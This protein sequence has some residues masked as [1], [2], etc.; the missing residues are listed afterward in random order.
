MSHRSRYV[1]A[2]V[3]VTCI[4]CGVFLATHNIPGGGGFGPTQIL[5]LV[6]SLGIGN[7]VAAR[8]LGRWLGRV[9]LGK[10]M[11][12]IPID[13]ALV[14]LCA[15]APVHLSEFWVGVVDLSWTEMRRGLESAADGYLASAR[16]LSKLESLVIFVGLSAASIAILWL[17]ARGE[18]RATASEPRIQS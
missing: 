4:W 10:A 15:L 7:Y 1:I 2:V 11:L 3:A 12:A 17:G 8:V 5:T 9:S 6:A 16:Q 13:L 14:L 18:K